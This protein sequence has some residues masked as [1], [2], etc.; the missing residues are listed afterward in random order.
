HPGDPNTWG[1][2]PRNAACPCQSGKKYKQCHG[3]A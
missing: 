2:I 3:K 1:K